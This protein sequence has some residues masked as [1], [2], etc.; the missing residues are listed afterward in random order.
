M[1][2]LSAYLR[3]VDSVPI[4]YR[5]NVCGFDF[6]LSP[7]GLDLFQPPH[8]LGVSDLAEADLL[9]YYTYRST[10]RTPIAVPGVYTPLDL[11]AAEVEALSPGSNLT[12]T[13]GPSQVP[14]LPG[15]GA[16]AVWTLSGA[17]EGAVAD[18]GDRIPRRDDIMRFWCDHSTRAWQV[19][20]T[21]TRGILVEHPR[22]VAHIWYDQVTNA[23]IKFGA[24]EEKFAIPGPFG[25][26]QIF[27]ER[28]ETSLPD[29]NMTFQVGLPPGMPANPYRDQGD[30]NRVI[31]TEAGFYFPPLGQAPTF[32]AMLT[33]IIEGRAGNP[34]FTDS[35]RTQ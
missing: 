34:V 30:T 1:E 6:I 5:P 33:E 7:D 31:I 25:L 19:S 8:P 12:S 21:V 35:S 26:R 14:G 10:G 28:L 29:N 17:W 16:T 24:Y 2:R 3:R 23:P 18:A 13:Q 27:R 15:G 32:N 11:P 20:G 22:V 9:G 4:H